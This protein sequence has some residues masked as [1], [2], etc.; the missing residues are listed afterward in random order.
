MASS[1][2]P[3][4][5]SAVRRA[6]TRAASGCPRATCAPRLGGCRRA[7][8]NPMPRG[9]R[10]SK[11]SPPTRMT[12]RCRAGSMASSRPGSAL[13]GLFRHQAMPVRFRRN[14]A[15]EGGPRWAPRRPCCPAPRSTHPRALTSC[16]PGDPAI[17][18]FSNAAA[19]ARL[20]RR[21]ARRPASCPCRPHLSMPTA[22]RRKET[23]GRR[24]GG[25][26]RTSDTCLTC[27]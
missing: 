1:P 23:S 8:I 11:A 16:S 5:R 6:N 22:L 12:R 15:R 3:D 14:Q 4:A 25:R 26:A 10:T 13:A 2:A 17:L 27:W 21:R 18:P 9:P 24:L 7:S 19:G 20:L